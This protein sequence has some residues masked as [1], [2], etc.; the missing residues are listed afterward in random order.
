MRSNPRL[1]RILGSL[2]FATGFL[3]AGLFPLNI[4]GEESI[5]VIES[6]PM[7]GT[8]GFYQGNR[9]PLRPDP[10]LKLPVGSISPGGWIAGQL[11]LMS[12]GFTGKLPEVSNYCTLQG[13]A[14]VDPQGRGEHGWEEVPYWLRGF[15]SLGYILDNESIIQE[16]ETWVE[17]VLNS[18]GE[19]GFMGPRGNW[20]R[21]QIRHTTPRDIWPNMV[22]LYVLRTY[23]DA[24]GDQR[25]LDFMTGYFRWVQQIPL[26]HFLH[27]TWQHWRGG[28]NLNSILWLYNRTGEEWLLDLARVNHDQTANWAGEIPTWH[29]VNLTMGYREPAQ[30]YQ[31]FQDPRYFQA[32]LRN[33]DTVMTTYGQVPGGMFGADENAREGYTGPRQAAESCSM[34]EF[35]HSHELMVAMTGDPVWA[36]RTEEIAFN[37]FP[38]AMTPDLK[39]LHYLTA[40]NMVQLDTADKS[41][42][43][44]NG[45]NMLAYSPWRYRCCQHNVS[46]GWPYY[47]ERLWM[48]TRDNGLAAVFYGE[49]TVRAKVADGQEVTIDQTTRYP[50]GDRINFE[51]STGQQVEFPLYLRV[52]G[53][54]E[55]VA[56][57]VN[58]EEVR[59]N[60]R[61]GAWIVL[62][63]SWTDGD[64]LTMELPMRI[65]VKR[66]TSNRNTA[67]V[68]RG[69]LTYSL[70]I[71]ERWERYGGT[72]EWPAY[73]VFPTTPWNYGL[74]LD[75]ENPGKDLKVIQQADELARQPFTVE[76]A[77]I[78]IQA[79]AKR[80]SAWTLEKNGLIGE[81]PE[82]PVTSE[83]PTESVTLIPMGAARLRVSAFPVIKTND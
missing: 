37:S 31:L 10:L 21:A 55:D 68:K 53:W 82:S 39:G 50:F 78:A 42:M 20:E 11:E 7:E 76:D 46:I 35:M 77:P 30:F 16:A 57:Q 44:Q 81:V 34:V 3:V 71:G 45:G 6:P 52:P 8:N 80:I 2:F 13:N 28:E 40:P 17:G 5:M 1:G 4:V 49:N 27:G 32:A 23:Y 43:I 70:K 73:E 51:I 47:A 41:P 54:A 33:Y 60:S 12:E 9:E 38:A 83:Q 56:V 61:A 67:S 64:H 65:E 48:A 26:E 58:G 59:V 24:T 75:A 29:G 69:P 22:M 62:S 19:N 79:Q 18:Q 25:V 15:I 72:E 14:W 63:R 36:D 74:V 66:W